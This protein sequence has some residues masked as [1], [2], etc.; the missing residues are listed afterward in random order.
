MSLAPKMADPE[1]S[2]LAPFD[3]Q[4]SAFLAETP[5]STSMN[6]VFEMARI[7]ATFSRQ[8]SMNFCPPKP[9]STVITRTMSLRMMRQQQPYRRGMNSLIASTEVFGLIV[10]PQSIPASW[11]WRMISLGSSTTEMD[12]KQLLAASTWK[13]NIFAPA[14]FR[15]VM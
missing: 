2:T 15:G 6:T 11:T 4:S 9:G 10:M 8:S 14:S 5:P 13:L 12:Q 1:T 3:A 7:S